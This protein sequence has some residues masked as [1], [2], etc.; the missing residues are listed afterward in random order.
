MKSPLPK[1]RAAAKSAAVI[2][3]EAISDEVTVPSSILSPVTE[4]SAKSSS[5]IVSSSILSPVTESSAN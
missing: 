5:S 1:E 4:S 2:V 3:F